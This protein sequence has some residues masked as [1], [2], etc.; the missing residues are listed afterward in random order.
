MYGD[1]CHPE[2]ITGMH[3]FL[4]VAEANR[5][6]NGFM[7]CPCS[8][9]K[10]MK[11]Y[12]TSKT[13]HVHLLENGFMPSYNCWTKHGER[14]VILEDN[15]E[16][17]DSD[18]YPLFTDQDGGSR[19]GEDEAEEELIFDEPIFDDPD[20]DLGRAILDAKMNCGNEKERLK[21]EKMLEDHNKLLYP[22]CENGQK[23]L[24]T[25]LELLQWKAENGTSD[26][27]FEKLLKIIKKMLPG[28]NVLPS[29]TYEAKKVVCPLGLE[30]QKIHA[31]IN[32]CILYRGEYENLNACPVCS[33]LRYKIRRDD[34]GDVEGE[35][36]PRKRVPAKVMW[37]AP[38]IPRLKRLFQNKE[39]AKLLRWHK[40][41][42]KKDVMLRH[43]A[44]GS[45]WRKIDRK[46]KSFSDDARNLIFGLSTDGFNPF[47]EQS[48]SHSTWP[49]TLCIYNLPPWL[50]MKR[51]FIMMPVLIQGP[52]QPG[53]DIDVY[54]R[55]LVEELLELWRDEGVPVWDEH[56][57]KEF[58]LRALL[59]VTIND[60]PALGN[61][62][63][64]SNKGYNACT[65]CLG[66]TDSNYLGNKNVYLG[67]RRFLPKQHHVRKRGKHFGGEADNRTKPTR[68]NGEVIYDMVK[69]LKVIFGK[70]PGGQSVPHDV[71]GHVPMWK[72]K[73]IFWELPYWKFLEV[74]SAIDVMHVTKNLCV[75]LLNFLGVY[76][77][78]KD[79]PDARQDQQ[80]IHEG[81]N[82]NPEK[83]QGPASYALTKEEK[84]IFFEVLSSIKVPSGFSS[85]I[86][87]II[88]MSEK[89][90]KT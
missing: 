1:R 87:G 68:P 65:H 12:S 23:K 56:E 9:C 74:H 10:N 79:T 21:L 63:G 22:N 42:R 81:N 53:N 20:D 5:R 48:S 28:E 27:G 82:L 29:S 45:Q 69:D 57:Q 72:K 16:E 39:R 52:K 18:N 84:E 14:G 60:W 66:E 26:K 25:T 86:K 6:S 90:F 31:C 32:D 17:E 38:I 37:Y 73:S 47:G 49:V 78:T 40:E 8:S 85:N 67:H 58:N 30:V 59:F 35:P 11:D 62:S 71:D 88:N 7:Y 24:G 4:N 76:G 77:K 34:P 33:A 2:F 75:N 64:Q 13:L 80:S 36:T 55:P 54:L 3:Y 15:E 51:K 19:M 44:D 83:Y 50:C 46:F 41:D 70:G 89:S 61:I 43:P